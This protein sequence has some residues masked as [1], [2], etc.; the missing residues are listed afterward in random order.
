M[1]KS[2]S[3]VIGVIAG[4]VIGVIGGVIARFTTGVDVDLHLRLWKHDAADDVRVQRY[5]AGGDG[6][7]CLHL[8]AVLHCFSSP[9]IATPS[10][11]ALRR[12][13]HTLTTLRTESG[14]EVAGREIGLCA[15]RGWGVPALRTKSGVEDAGG[16]RGLCVWRGWGMRP[17]GRA[18]NTNQWE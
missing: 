5:L 7:L 9:S 16:E 11:G 4:V 18:I 6:N 13:P 15:W 8:H 12:H 14:I 3:V 17:L 1:T 10:D 2:L